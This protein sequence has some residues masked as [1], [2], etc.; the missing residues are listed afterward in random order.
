MILVFL[1]LA[2]VCGRERTCAT[3]ARRIGGLRYALIYILLSL[4][5]VS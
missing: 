4:A 1:V 3:I 5:V 2:R